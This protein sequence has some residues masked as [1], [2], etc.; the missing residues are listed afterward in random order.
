MAHQIRNF[1]VVGGGCFATQYT[2]WLLRSV[3]LNWLT[4]EKIICVDKNPQ[5]K[6]TKEIQDPR[7]QLECA[8]WY[9]FFPQLIINHYQDANAQQD[10]WIP[11]HMAPHILFHS[12][13]KAIKLLEA[14]GSHQDI[15]SIS[16]QEPFHTPV[17]LEL[18]SG[19]MAVSF[20]EWRCP[21]NCI[22]PTRC[23]AIQDARTWEMRDT[24]QAHL[25]KTSFDSFH[26]LQCQ[27]LCHAV[28]TIPMMQIYQEFEKLLNKIK[29][30]K[31][32]SFAIAT[33]SSCHG[34][35][36]GAKIL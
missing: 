8:E 18:A 7:V 34:L 19:D 12:F 14:I 13:I 35:I 24:M 3:K 29:N 26:Y 25:Q 11:S 32:E 21:M 22:E 6:V 16:F 4:F 36:S 15:V 33:I 10:H 28:G 31:I 2:Q 20:A 5:C 17:R 30:Q 23:P 27:H 1:Y 9:D